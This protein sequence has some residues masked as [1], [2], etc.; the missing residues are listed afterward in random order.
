MTNVTVK[1]FWRHSRAEIVARFSN[2]QDASQW[3]CDAAARGWGSG[4]C[5]QL[6]VF[7]GVTLVHVFDVKESDA[8]RAERDAKRARA[9]SNAFAERWS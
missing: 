7:S 6:K 5:A 8:Q 4:D 2:M 1:A 3:A 9:E